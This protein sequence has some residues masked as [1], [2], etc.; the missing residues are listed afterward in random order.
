[1]K[2]CKQIKKFDIASLSLTSKDQELLAKL[3]SLH[4]PACWSQKV[5]DLPLTQLE[6]D[7]IGNFKSNLKS[8][9][10]K[11]GQ[12]RYCCFCAAE[13]DPHQATFDLEHLIAKAEKPSV[14]FHL[15]NL[16][17][18]CK[19]CNVN[20][21]KSRVLLFPLREDIDH[22]YLDSSLYL[23]V[24][25]HLDNWTDHLLIDSY[26]RILPKENN[27]MGKGAK[28][29]QICGVD[30]KNAMRLADWFDIFDEDTEKYDDW[31]AFYV[32]LCSQDD[33]K[34]K[35]KYKNFLKNLLAL[36]SDPAA[37]RL[38]CILEPIID[39]I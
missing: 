2:N 1:M 17:L 30:K 33:E 36:P 35:V 37:D 10:Y 27:F 8:Y 11:V 18:S 22:V 3:A 4:G 38:R 31:V 24:H 21:G 5:V 20:K 9:L 28:T 34:R 32:A 25:P 7:L 13:L 23:I 6:R 29:I 15:Q 39:S 14:V 16:A 12:G 26:G 19:T